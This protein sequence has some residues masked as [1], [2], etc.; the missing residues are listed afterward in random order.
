MKI[1]RH[2]GYREARHKME[3]ITYEKQGHVATIRFNRPEKMNAITPDMM[4]QLYQC[5]EEINADMDI[6]S[7]VVTGG[8]KV[9]CSGSDIKKL[10]T[11]DTP[12]DFHNR[13]KDYPTSIRLIRKPVIAMVNGYCL[14][15]GLEMAISADMRYAS[16]S[17][18]FGAPEI[19]H[20]WIGGGGASQILPRL[21]GPGLAAEMLISGK[22]YTASEA[23]DMGLVDRLYGTPQEL[24]SA[25]YDMAGLI[26]SKAPIAAQVIKKAV[27]V[28]QNIGLDAG[29]DYEN[30]L[31]YITFSTEDKEEG[32]RAFIEKRE[33]VFKG[34]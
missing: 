23:K 20:G 30:E 17:A 14:G 31:V 3:T 9:F 27:R 15:G 34:R 18:R 33:P 12:W 24:E 10:V 11:Y 7:V 8:D 13:Q 25:T 26:A 19:N 29:L 22:T 28:S 1:L 5:V 2:S 21:V 16:E 32:Q 4:V 6:R